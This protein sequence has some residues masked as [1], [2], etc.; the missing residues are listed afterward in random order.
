MRSSRLSRRKKAFRCGLLFCTACALWISGRAA[1]LLRNGQQIAQHSA[2]FSRDYFV[3]KPTAP[4]VIYLVMG[5]STAAGWGAQNVQQTFA[6]LVAETIAKRGFRV[7]VVNVAVGGARLED[8]LRHQIASLDIHPQLVAISIGANDATHGTSE[9]EYS[10]QWKQLLAALQKS[11]A[12]TI[13]IANTPDMF[14]APALPSLLAIV[15]GNRARRQ[16]QILQNVARNSA[17]EIVD[18]HNRGKLVYARD[19]E[20]YALDLFHPSDEGYA[21]WAQL[22]IQSASKFNG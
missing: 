7:R 9:I 8:V 3:G 16:N 19:H 22:F 20:L 1:I 21:I 10:N 13:L 5:D 6:Y 17:I 15:A 11:T 2:S 14:Q 18:L 4:V 12:Q